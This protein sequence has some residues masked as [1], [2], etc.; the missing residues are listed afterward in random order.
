MVSFLGITKPTPPKVVSFRGFGS[1]GYWA[2][3]HFSPFST[4]KCDDSSDFGS[5]MGFA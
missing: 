1:P 5:T 2:L 3:T 4:A